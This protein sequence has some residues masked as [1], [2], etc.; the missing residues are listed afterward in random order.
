MKTSRTS[1]ARHFSLQG[2]LAVLALLLCA[3][4]APALADIPG[5]P[6]SVS[7]YDSREVAMLPRFCIH[8]QLF[9]DAVPG[10]NNPTEIRKLQSVMGETFQAIHHY[11]WAM[12][13]TNRALILARSQKDRQFYLSD[14]I[15]EFDYVI[16]RAPADF[17]LL[18]EILTKKGE[19]LLRLGRA[20]EAVGELRRAIEIKPDYWPPSIVL[21]DHYKATGEIAKAREILTAALGYSPASKSVK[22]RLAA[23]NAAKGKRIVTPAPQP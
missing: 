2:I 10:G 14:S 11:C 7:A 22:E 3:A 18:P 20:V 4:G 12:M 19:N 6:S 13:K 17:V 1:V 5:Y 23:L 9:R 8:T 15:G 16:Q 21:S